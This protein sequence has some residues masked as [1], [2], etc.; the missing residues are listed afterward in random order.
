MA[1][2]QNELDRFLNAW[3]QIQR[4]MQAQERL[5][6]LADLRGMTVSELQEILDRIDD[7]LRRLHAPQRPTRAEHVD[8]ILKHVRPSE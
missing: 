2:Y 7:G 4:D 5:Q 8:F 6:E 3:E 1:D